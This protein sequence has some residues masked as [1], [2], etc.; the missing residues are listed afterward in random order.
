MTAA[1]R[2]ANVNL[3]PIEVPKALQDGEKFIKWDE[4]SGAG[5]P[6][7]LRVDPKGFFV[8]WT[9]QNM[10]VELLDIAYIRDVRTGVFAKVPKDPKIRNVVLIGSQGSLEEKTVTI[11][12]GA[13]FVNVT[14]INFC[15]TRK[16]IAQLWTDELFGLAYNLNQL[17]NP[18]IKFLEKLHT[19][20]TLKADKSG[21]IL[22]KNIVRTFAQNKEDK[23]RVEKALSE[24][25]LPTS[26]NDTISQS[27]FQFEDFFAFYKNLTQR[28]EAQKIFNTLTDG[29]PHLAATQL[30]E[31]LNE[32]QRDPRLNEIL[33]PYADLQRA[34][35]LIKIYEHN[36]YHQQRSQLTFDG[37]LRFLMS[38]DNP[39]VAQSKLDLSDDMDQPLAHYFINSSHNTYLTGHQITGKSSV[40][41]YRQSL[42]AGC[43][44]QDASQGFL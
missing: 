30:V 21:K 22:V 39:I 10:E 12:Y 43:R 17:N 38:E 11:C 20:I 26:K 42:L 13:D 2:P 5:V 15:C 6:V 9:D 3:K 4:D 33:H 28:N 16:E 29:K 18:T 27:K 35:D 34:K 8:Y 23:K 41:I 40:E 19:K 14:F 32:V 36:K 25:G 24:S 31:F 7:T 44:C 37:F 1:P